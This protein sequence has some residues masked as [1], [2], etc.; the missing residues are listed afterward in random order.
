MK[1]T[2][3]ELPHHPSNGIN[4]QPS[5]ARELAAWLGENDHQS[6]HPLLYREIISEEFKTAM[7]DLAMERELMSYRDPA[8]IN[9]NLGLIRFF[10]RFGCQCIDTG[11]VHSRGTK[12]GKLE[13]P[14][15]SFVEIAL[16]PEIDLSETAAAKTARAGQLAVA[17][18]RHA[19][20]DDCASAVAKTMETTLFKYCYEREDLKIVTFV[21]VAPNTT[22]AAVVAS[23]L[24]EGETALKQLE[25]EGKLKI[26]PS[27][28]VFQDFYNEHAM[29]PKLEGM[30]DYLT[31][32]LPKEVNAFYAP[33]N[34]FVQLTAP[35]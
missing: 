18:R 31:A 29:N 5:N 27:F 23:Y 2:L 13:L 33:P 21:I 34:Y 12:V 20:H 10:N 30:L 1:N 22:M 7:M 26:T 14:D 15:G 28:M 11:I 8:E 6:D 32:L 25:F 16:T 35:R 17:Q 9:V 19:S 24:E 4:F 3:A